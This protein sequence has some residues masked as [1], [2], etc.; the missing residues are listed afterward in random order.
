M[1]PPFLSRMNRAAAAGAFTDRA[2]TLPESAGEA[3]VEAAVKV[4]ALLEA[5]ENDEEPIP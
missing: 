3:A 2:S 5:D 1:V 4:V